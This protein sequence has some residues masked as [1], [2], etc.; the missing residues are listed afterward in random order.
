MTTIRKL[1]ACAALALAVPS[2]ALA[3]YQAPP[4]QAPAA[5]APDQS[6]AAP[7]QGAPAAA[8]VGANTA[9]TGPMP[10]DQMPGG[11]ASALSMGDNKLVTNGPVPDTA[12]NRAKYGGP[13]S[14]AGRHT[15]PIGN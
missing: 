4:A 13:M 12:A 9:S 7:P 3:Q 8:D 15:K 11:Q 14:N 1:A 5:A 2:M 6:M 10:A